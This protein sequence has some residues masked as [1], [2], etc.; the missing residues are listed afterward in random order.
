MFSHLHVHSCYSF[1]HGASHVDALVAAARDRGISHLALTDTNGFYG[2][3]FFLEAARREGIAPVVGVELTA[4]DGQ[5]L[6]LAKTPESYPCL[7]ELVSRCHL[8]DAFSLRAALATGLPGVA[9]LSADLELL[10]VLEG[11][12]ELHVEICPGQKG[13]MPLRFAREHDL[14]LVATNRVYFADA[15]DYELHCLLRA[16]DLNTTL[17]NL[18]PGEVASPEQWLKGEKD[19]ACH[20]PHCPEAMAGAARL[21]QHC[22]TDWQFAQRIFPHYRDQQHDHFE[23]LQRKCLQGVEQRYGA[24]NPAVKERLQEELALIRDKG[25]TDYFLIVAD[26]VRRAPITCGRGSAAASLVSYLLGIT[27]VDPVRHQLYFGRFLSPNRRDLPDIDVDFP[28][29]ERDEVLD[30]VEKT[31]G[32]ERLAMVANHVG[33]RARAAVREV[34]KVYGIP[35]AEIA[36]VTR[37]LSS[38]SAPG[39]ISQRLASH[40]K[41][42]G[43]RLEPPWPEIFRLAARLEGIPR[44]ISVHCGGTVIVPEK[45]SS[46]V[47]VQLAPKG[48]RVIQWEKEQTEAAGLVKIDLL[49]NRSLAVIRDTLAAIHA[50]SGRRISYAEL[51][52]LDDPATQRLLARGETMGV[53]YV[54]SPAMRRLQ[55]MT[56]RGDYQHLVIHSSIIRPAANRYVLEYVRRLKGIP[57]KSIHPLLDRVLEETYGIMVYQEDV[58][59][60][61]MELA[62]FDAAEADC[63]RKTLTKKSR[64][65]LPDYRQR[66]YRGCRRRGV[67]QRVIDAVWQMMESFGGYSFC[68]P[69]SASYAL[70]SFKSAYLKAHYPAEFMAAVISNGGGYYS[71]FAY[72]SEA[73]RLGLEV[74]GPDINKSELDYVGKNRTL[75]VGLKQLQ[76]LSRQLQEKIREKRQQGG[77]FCSLVDF[78]QRVNPEPAACRLLVQSGSLDSIAGN[79]NRPQMLWW[80]YGHRQPRLAVGSVLLFPRMTPSS[81]CPAI[82]DYDCLTKLRHQQETMGFILSVHPLR[83]YA[84][85]KIAAS[86]RQVVPAKQLSRHVGRRVTVAAW[87]IT[88][89]EILTRAGE[90]MEFV[91]FE[92]ETGIFEATFFPAAYRRYCQII[93]MNR[94]YLLKGRVTEEEGAIS[95]N[96]EKIWRL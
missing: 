91:S 85:K 25:F 73:R 96:V 68:K 16:I 37:R 4:R 33:F 86:G 72:I 84:K 8:E 21:A 46:H 52:P 20:F 66:F 39:K 49:G 11:K 75:R 83:C 57:Y 70:V 78:R 80:F 32:R 18:P 81:G 15:N 2:L 47:P 92:D 34:A 74:R 77:P 89:K 94:A 69:H 17:A 61:A 56:G 62:G 22:H 13:E 59:R 48:V 42:Q 54:E 95:L 19:M 65:Q 53:F 12:A 31:Y 71:T 88:G 58:S 67:P 82:A 23:L 9:V 90:A 5:A 7:S 24:M 93:D 27:H 1:M 79:L 64:Q 26:I 6:L 44:H 30:F 14:P 36:R 40:P 45:V 28:W 10:S 60:V 41:F 50:N 87:S 35:A 63:L 51:N 55:Q 3:P 43:V 29:D 76:G 38:F